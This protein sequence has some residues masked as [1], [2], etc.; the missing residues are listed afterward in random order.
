MYVVKKVLCSSSRLHFDKFFFFYDKIFFSTFV[1]QMKNL[2]LKHCSNESGNVTWRCPVKSFLVW[3]NFFFSPS[4]LPYSHDSSWK[5]L[6]RWRV[7]LSLSHESRTFTVLLWK[8][9]LY[10]EARDKSFAHLAA[11]SKVI[12]TLPSQYV[13][14]KISSANWWRSKKKTSK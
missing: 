8:G 3:N 7:F 2:L 1:T 11:S 5:I 12:N 6:I 14:S 4:Q 13:K 9:K 10:K